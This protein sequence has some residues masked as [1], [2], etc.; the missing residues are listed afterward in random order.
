MIGSAACGSSKAAP[1][2][3]A[4]PDSQWTSFARGLPADSFPPP[5]RRFS[6]IVAPRW[7][8]ETTRD[9]ANEAET[10][11][12]A[13]GVHPGMRVADVGAGDGYYVSRLAQRVGA[14]GHVYGEDIVPD[15]LTL[16]ARRV[17]DERLGN[18]TVIRGDAHDPRLPRDTAER[19]DV[20]TMI[21]MYHEVTDPY[22]FLWNLAHSLKP[23]ALVGVLDMTFAT[24]RH[25]TP[26]W[27]L[28]CELGVVGYRKVRQQETGADEYLAIFRAPA[29]DS[30][31]SP[32]AIREAVRG[33]ACQ[34][35]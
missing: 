34:Q 29:A 20:V 18:V 6:D 3:R 27:L 16:L 12:S 9:A 23:G 13:L 31:R 11:M 21:H 4:A 28:D 1:A 25:G 5:S 2:E 35:R 22:A 24:D 33:G 8:D 26:P 19:V 10:V 7:T 17:T 30:L 32:A 15:Y 14:A